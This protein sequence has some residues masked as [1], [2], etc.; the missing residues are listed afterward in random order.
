MLSVKRIGNLSAA[1]RESV[2][3]RSTEDIDRVLDYVRGIVAQVREKGDPPVLD[4]HR[5]LK[6]DVGPQDLIASEEE[7]ETAFKEVDPEIIEALETARANI[8]RFHQAQR[9]RPMWTM[10]NSPGVIMGRMSVPLDSVGCYVPGGTA[11]YPSSVLMTVIPAKVAGVGKVVVASPPGPG[12]EMNP[13]TLAAAR[14]A[15]ADVVV[16]AGGPFAVA[17]LAYGTATI[18]RVDKIVGPGNKY[19]TAAKL[20]VFGQVDID[21][22]AGPSESLILCDGTAVP[23]HM[24]LDFLSQVEHDPDAGAVLVS[25]SARVAEETCG[26]INEIGPT[27]ARQEQL[28]SALSRHSH[29]LLADTLDQAIDLANDYAAEHLQIVTEEPWAVLPRIRHAG[30]IFMGPYAPVP[31][32]DYVSGTNHVLPTGRMARVFSGLSLDDFIK[33]PTFQYLTR[34][35]LAG[36]KDTVTTLARAEGLPVHGLS[37]RARFEE[38]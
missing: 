21:S 29:V 15:G 28:A 16:K 6:S 23:R 33:K 9:E 10:E 32:G 8:R 4:W 27:L 35:G 18:P 37:V 3:T 12:M 30:S 36:L 26:L 1:E 14:I 20:I 17:A 13:A 7:I 24:A 5:E 19:V 11:A 34:E 2:L 22:P 31:V 38:D 25:T